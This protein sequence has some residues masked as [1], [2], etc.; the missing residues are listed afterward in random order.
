MGAVQRALARR[1][2]VAARRLD[3]VEKEERQYQDGQDEAGNGKAAEEA[4][5]R[6]GLA[7]FGHAQ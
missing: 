5:V 1:M 6:I 2:A 3:Q 7:Q 4:V